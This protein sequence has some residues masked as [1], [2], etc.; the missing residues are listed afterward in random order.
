M[1][2][3]KFLLCTIAGTLILSHLSAAC[4]STATLIETPKVDVNEGEKVLNN[5]SIRDRIVGVNVSGEQSSVKIKG[6]SITSE[7]LLFSATKGAHIHAKAITAK[8]M[9]TGLQIGN[10]TINLEDSI[11]TVKGNHEAY[12]I[13]FQTGTVENKSEAILTKTKLS[14]KDGIGIF[15]ASAGG[16]VKIKDSEIHADLLLKNVSM[17]LMPLPSTLTV[18]ADHSILKG[19]ARTSQEKTTILTLNNNSK[20]IVT[21]GEGETDNDTNLFSYSLRSLNDRAHSN[22]STLNL[23]N[24]TIFFNEPINGQYQTL[25]VGQQPGADDALQR[26][27]NKLPTVGAV[28]TATGDAKIYTNLKWSDGAAKTEQKAD[29]LLVYGD[30]SGTTTIYLN[31]ISKNEDIKTKDTVPLNAR[32]ISLVQVSG[33]ASENAFK[34][35]NGYTT[36]NGYPYKYVLNAYGPT[37]K[38]GKGKANAEQNVLGEGEGFWDFR[39]QNA[40]LDPEAKI[41][42]LVPQAA[43]YLVMPHALFSAGFS[44]ISNQNI[45]LD[46]IKEAASEPKNDKKQGIEIILSSYGDKVTLS[47]QRN[48]NQYGYGADINYAALQAGATL[49]SL[50]NQSFSTSFG[51]LGTYGK[52][53]FTPKDM[54]ESGKSTLDKWSFTAYSRI[55][56]N[57]GMYINALFSYGVLNGNITTNIIKDTAKISDA[58]ALSVSATLGQRLETGASGLIFEPQ[59]Q[60]IYQNLLFDTIKDVDN[61][62]VDMGKPHQ[63]LVRAGGRLVQNVLNDEKDGTVSFYAKLNVIKAFGDDSAIK[64]GD[65]LHLDSRGASIQGGIGVDAQLLQNVELR[66]DVS[67]QYRLQ[68]S[69]ISGVSFSGGIRYRF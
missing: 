39:L 64:I 40:Y 45:L 16:N 63:W 14:V 9:T 62:V 65:S 29:R 42:A 61:F 2:K 25:S 23:N 11:V 7:L 34:L 55:E 67:Y 68:K 35:A 53:D 19:K 28:Y 4:A 8:T 48:P 21:I 66:G 52:L 60:L 50:E 13:V 31:D 10:S 26:N 36:I 15:G 5:V 18:V 17:M 37:S 41:K 49:V 3:K 6:G 56:H 12:G 47:S 59:A 20:W 22:V 58:K 69:G 24:S 30:V 46:R 38:Q 44:D 32:G 33:T 1:Y 54:E 57:N 43:S 27:E 51:L